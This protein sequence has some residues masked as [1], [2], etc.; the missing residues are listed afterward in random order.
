MPLRA[1]AA[2]YSDA[3][4]NSSAP[5]ASGCILLRDLVHLGH[6]GIDLID[7]RRRPKHD[8]PTF[9]PPIG[10]KEL[11]IEPAAPDR[12]VHEI[13]EHQAA[14]SPDQIA[15]VLDDKQLSCA[16]LDVRANGLARELRLPRSD[17]D[18]L[19]GLF[20][21]RSIKFVVGMLAIIQAQ[22]AA[23]AAGAAAAAAA[24]N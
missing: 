22:Q 1:W 10:A 4:A 16:E 24:A 3:D 9:A 6:G 18:V 13:L 17:P 8:R 12:C 5:A 2:S 11:A 14:A 21:D 7:T 15:V 20:A 23:V 19:I